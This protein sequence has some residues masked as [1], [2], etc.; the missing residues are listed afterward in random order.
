[1]DAGRAQVRA[2]VP[3]HLLDQRRIEARAPCQRHRIRRRT[4]R[5]EARQA[6]LVGDRRDAEAARRSDT[7]LR[8]GQRL[9]AQLRVHRRR[10]EGTGELA[11][12]LVISSAQS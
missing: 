10:T 3:G 6:L 4:P 9:R 11:K 8:A 5:R 7:P 12:T 2:D 1:V